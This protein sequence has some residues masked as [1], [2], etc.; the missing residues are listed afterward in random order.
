MKEETDLE[1]WEN[2]LEE[3]PKYPTPLTN[4]AIGYA[5]AKIERLKDNE[6]G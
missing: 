6:K 2:I 5:K 1:Y 4:H 3:L